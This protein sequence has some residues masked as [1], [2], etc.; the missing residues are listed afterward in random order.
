MK[1][2]AVVFLMLSIGT[3]Y[4]LADG[5]NP[6]GKIAQNTVLA[7]SD[8]AG[9][10]VPNPRAL[11]NNDLPIVTGAKGGT[12]VNNTGTLTFSGSGTLATGGFTLT[13]PATGTAALLGTANTFTAANIVQNTLSIKDSAGTGAGV[14]KLQDT[15]GGQFISIATASNEAADRTLTIPLLGGNDTLV[16]LGLAQTISGIKTH[17]ATPINSQVDLTTGTMIYQDHSNLRVVVHKF[18]WSN[19]LIT[20]LGAVNAGD[21]TVC[22]LPNATVVKN[23]Y[24]T[25]TTPDTSANALTIA[26]GRTGASYIDYIVASDAK[27]AANTVY[28]DVVGERGTNLTG[29]DL[30]SVSG[31]SAAVKAHFIKTTTTLDTVVGSTGSIYIETYTLP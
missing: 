1:K 16:T 7:G 21:V 3:I 27:A 12:G 31:T 6:G 4:V 14:L 28:G 9:N 30:H 24:V 15:S 10:A 25:I 11:V 8:G 19:G 17:S 29:Y 23:V 18:T 5:W 20:A 2:F 26:V 13:V 22:T